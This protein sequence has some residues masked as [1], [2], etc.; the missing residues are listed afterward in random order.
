MVARLG[1]EINHPDSIYY[2]AYRN[3]IPVF[4]PALT[5]QRL[6]QQP[7]CGLLCLLLPVSLLGSSVPRMLTRA[8]GTSL[9]ALP[10][11]PSPLS[12]SH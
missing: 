9:G 4:C 5:G 3:N 6:Q 7:G 1:K 12:P 10:T 11:E 8:A 2:W